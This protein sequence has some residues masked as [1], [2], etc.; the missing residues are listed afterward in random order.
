MAFNHFT[1]E[2]VDIAIIE[3]GLGGRLDSTNI[4]SPELC[5]ITNIGY[6]HTTLLGNTLPEIAQEKAGIIKANTPVIIGRK[7]EEIACLFEVKKH[8]SR[9][10]LYTIQNLAFSSDLKG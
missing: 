9:M 3:T 6:D 4:L 1:E 8:E 7:Q 10:S 5:I 2:K